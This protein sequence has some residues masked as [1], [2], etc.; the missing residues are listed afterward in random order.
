MYFKRVWGKP[1]NLP[2]AEVE[3]DSFGYPHGKFV[4]SGK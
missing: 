3:A 4:W 1:P 2:G